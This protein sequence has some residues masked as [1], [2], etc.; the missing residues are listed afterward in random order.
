MTIHSPQSKDL[1]PVVLTHGGEWASET[2]RQIALGFEPGATVQFETH[3]PG[4]P[5]SRL[6]VAFDYHKR[7]ALKKV[8]SASTQEVEWCARCRYLRTLPAQDSL[9]R[10]RSMRNAWDDILQQSRPVAVFSEAIDSYV[11]S[12][13]ENVCAARG[14]PFFGLV[15]SFINGYCRT[16]RYGELEPVRKLDTNEVATVHRLLTQVDY[17]PAFLAQKSQHRKV[18]LK[19]WAKNWTRFLFF[20]FKMIWSRNRERNHIAGA[21]HTSRTNLHFWPCFDIGDQDWNQT[22]GQSSL[23]SVFV[24]LQFV[25]E[26]TIDYW[27]ESVDLIKHDDVLVDFISKH[28]EHFQFVI[29]EHP[30]AQGLRTPKLY[31]R[32]KKIK[33]VIFVPTTVPIQQVL[34]KVDSVLTWTGSVGLQAALQGKPVFNFCNAYYV[35]GRFFSVI[36]SDSSEAEMCAHIVGVTSNS[37]SEDEKMVLIAHTLSGHIP[38]ALRFGHQFSAPSKEEVARYRAIG[39][40]IRNRTYAEA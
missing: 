37:I 14:I 22:L 16:T 28:A 8:Q 26:A 20:A 25:P 23:L 9:V 1:S 12:T 10:L 11:I 4:N 34:D 5:Q 33:N 30:N 31:D 27:C 32:L 39:N 40:A 21:F 6:S 3:V 24:P 29:K 2:L 36:D 17:Q 13:L 18:V 19:A 35:K 15:T 38:G 7:N